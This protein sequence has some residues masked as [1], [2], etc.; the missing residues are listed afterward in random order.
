MNTR[1]ENLLSMSKPSMREM[2][3][4]LSYVYW[5]GVII[6]LFFSC[7]ILLFFIDFRIT[8]TEKDQKKLT[9]KG[10][11]GVFLTTNTLFAICCWC[12]S[13]SWLSCFAGWVRNRSHSLRLDPPNIHKLSDW[14]LT[15]GRNGRGLSCWLQQTLFLQNTCLISCSLGSWQQSLTQKQPI[16]HIQNKTCCTLVLCVACIGQLFKW[17]WCTLCFHR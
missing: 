4:K 9:W 6:F 5:I 1:H 2:Y 3:S 8:T 7:C 15:H 13:L 12:G 10:N 14:K 17:L 16:Y 11:G